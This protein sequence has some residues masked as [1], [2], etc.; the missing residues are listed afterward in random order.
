MKIDLK[1]CIFELIDGTPT[2]VGPPATA[3]KTLEINI[4]EGTLTW[5]EKRNIEYVKNRGLLDTTRE[6]DQDPVDIRFDFVWE[7]LRSSSGDTTPTPYEV[8]KNIGAAST[9]KTTGGDPC[10]P[11][12]I[13]IRITHSFPCGGVDDE[14]VYFDQFRYESMDG[15]PKA[16][17]I[18]VTGKANVI[19]PTITRVA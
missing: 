1:H 10:E 5:S 15:D 7:E 17:T 4:G 3:P 9:W 16:G 12:A 19:A 8:L 13:D 14:I 2:A 18:S 6:G 11:F